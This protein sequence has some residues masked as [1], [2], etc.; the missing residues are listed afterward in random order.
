MYDIDKF[1]QVTAEIRR[2]ILQVQKRRW[3]DSGRIKSTSGE[4]VGKME[5]IMKR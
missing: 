2:Y 3:T 4:T 1:A 5:N